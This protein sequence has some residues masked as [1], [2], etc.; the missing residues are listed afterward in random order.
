MLVVV[1]RLCQVLVADV[2]WEEDQWAENFDFV[3]H[4]LH[5]T[6]GLNHYDI[7]VEMNGYSEEFFQMIID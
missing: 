4:L 1:V 2:E 5:Q 7:V 3:R 6:I